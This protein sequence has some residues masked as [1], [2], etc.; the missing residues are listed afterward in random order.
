[1]FFHTHQTKIESMIIY[2][3]DWIICW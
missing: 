3:R 1:M 2:W